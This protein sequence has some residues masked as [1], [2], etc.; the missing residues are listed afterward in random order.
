M[1]KIV[2][3][4]VLGFGLA[5]LAAAVATPALAKND[6][7]EATPRYGASTTAP[8][9][10]A[11]VFEGRNATEGGAAAE[12]RNVTVGGSATQGVEPY[13]ASQIEQNA[14]ASR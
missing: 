8:E 4:P 3:L 1:S 14:R 2:S 10:Y 12:G 5:V 6:G 13:I 9:T 11:P 7:P